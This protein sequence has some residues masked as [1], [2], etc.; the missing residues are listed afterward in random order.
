MR[1]SL[2]GAPVLIDGEIGTWDALLTGR[3]FHFE[4]EAVLDT[5][6]FDLRGRIDDVTDLRRPEIEFTATGP[7]VDDLTR[8]LGL[9]DEGE[10][11]I[12]L[13]GS[14]LS[15]TDGP[16]TL[17]VD[18]HIGSTQVEASGSIA[19]LK[20]LDEIGLKAYATGPDLSRVLRI[21]GIHQLRKT[22][23]MIH[24]DAETKGETFLLKEARAVFAEARIDASAEMPNFPGIDDA[25]IS[26]QIEGP[27]IERFRHVTRL[28]G[29]ATGAFSLGFTVDVG[30]D[31]VEIVDLAVRTSLGQIRADGRL[32]DPNDFLGTRVN[33]NVASDSLGRVAGAYGLQGMPD[34]AIELSGSAEYNREGIRTIGPVSATVAAISAEVEGLVALTPGIVGTDL[35]FD[36]GGPDLAEVV[37]YFAE[38]NFVPALPYRATGQ[39]QLRE[40]GLRFRNIEGS[41]GTSSI[42]GGG[43]LVPE[44]LIPGSWFVAEAAGP[45]FEEV[46]AS[47]SDAEVRPG[48]YELAGRIDFSEDSIDLSG[49]DLHRENGDVQVNLGIGMPAERRWLDF[50]V[51]A[52]GA[53]VRSML[54]GIRN[55]EAH[56]QPFRMDVQGNLRGTYWSFD[57]LQVAIGEATIEASG[58]LEFVEARANTDF[59]FALKVPDLSR[60]GKIKGRNLNQQPLAIA[61][62]V[63]GGDGKVEFRQLEARIG[64]S[65][66]SGVVRLEAGDVPDITV[67]VNSDELIYQPLL[68]KEEKFEYEPEPE[69]KDG[70]LIPD[71]PVPFEAMKK[72]NATLDIDIGV[73]MRGELLMTDI[74]LDASLRDGVL[75]VPRAAFKARS[76]AMNARARLDPA[77]GAGHASLQLVARRLAFGMTELNRDLAMTGDLDIDLSSTGTDLRTLLG[78]ANGGLFVDVRGGRVTNNR[79][80]QALYGDLLQEILGTINPFRQTDPYTDFRCIVVPLRLDDGKLVSAPSAFVST[81]RIR[82]AATSSVN[83]KNER[84][85]VTVRT[86]PQRALSISAGE[87]VNPYVQ[88][89]GTLAAPRLSVDETGLLVSGGAAVATG[90]LSILAKGLWDRLSREAE[91]C[92]Q[93]SGQAIQALGDRFPDLVIDGFDRIE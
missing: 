7:D 72:L 26:V 46:I 21:A 55:F 31:G 22:P 17:E 3:D 86:T 92:K 47:I 44:P 42:R 66:I 76:G 33:F 14:L 79:F 93:V 65:D 70:R 71:F 54:R 87:L 81:S 83:L 28:P 78:N 15:Y 77:G 58:D 12:Q 13:S 51:R 29:A 91:P 40:D 37:G 23:F 69:F 43:L 82:I 62:H 10:G 89:V 39:M 9:G 5:F 34:K 4:F 38:P 1:A 19:D 30:A 88:V 85:Q 35:T 41:L 20:S 90:G 75:D 73:L 57:R 16:L 53:N 74:E 64:N 50:D 56:P 84:L 24:I 59:G 68:E 52:N 32:G 67:D 49:I 60:L 80:L 8:L 25:V 63:V 61:A 48:P 45:A 2:D 18:G 6:T 27:D 11:D 36:A